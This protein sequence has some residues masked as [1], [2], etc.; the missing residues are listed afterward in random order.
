MTVTISQSSF[1]L[2]SYS[3][4]VDGERYFSAMNFV[5]VYKKP[6]WKILVYSHGDLVTFDKSNP[7]LDS[8][9]SA[10]D[11]GLCI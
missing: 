10:K 3:S 7:I 4:F 6:S 11:C 1:S 8:V 2:W 5:P 9:K